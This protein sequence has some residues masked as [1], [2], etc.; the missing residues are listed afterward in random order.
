MPVYRNHRVLHIHIPKTAGTTIEQQFAELGDMHWDASCRYGRVRR[1][2]RWYEDHHLTLGEL[3]ALSLDDARW[4]DTFAV[5]RDPYQRLLSEYHWRHTLVYE[6]QAPELLAFETFDAMVAAI[7]RDLEHNWDRYIGLADRDH[8]NLLIHLRPQWHY[9]CDAAGRPDEGVEIVR[10]EQLRDDLEPLYRRWHVAT[11]PFGAPRPPLDLAEYYSD[12]SLA[13]V[14]AV[15][16]RDF[17]MFGY[18]RIDTV[19]V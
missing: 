16:A 19:A 3:R 17:E 11:R 9:V 6:R 12:E 4:L 15:Y 1:P 8:A 13:V 2:D 5:V 14:N 10:F 7:P 18:E